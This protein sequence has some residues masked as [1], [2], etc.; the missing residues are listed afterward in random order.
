MEAVQ[1]TS[2][3]GIYFKPTC[4]QVDLIEKELASTAR[5]PSGFISRIF[6]REGGESIPRICE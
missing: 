2:I 3:E 6:D 4:K 5:Y 1:E